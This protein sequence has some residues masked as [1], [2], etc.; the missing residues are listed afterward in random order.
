MRLLTFP[1]AYTIDISGIDSLIN[2]PL[3]FSKAVLTLS[4]PIALAPP[5]AALVLD[6]PPF[7]VQFCLTGLPVSGNFIDRDMEME[8]IE[9][10]L[11]PLKLQYR[12]RIHVLHG[13]GGIGKTQLAI[14]Y[15]RKY[16]ERYSAILWLNGNSYD[17]LLQSFSSFATHAGINGIQKSS[18]KV[19]AQGQKT[20]EEAKA[21]LQWLARKE[22]H[23]WLM[24]FDNVDREDHTENED[25][26]A[27]NIE[28]FFPDTDH[29][30]ILITTRLSHLGQLGTQSKV[31]TVNKEQAFQ[32]FSI[33]SGLSSDI[34]GDTD[35]DLEIIN[36]S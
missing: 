22:N 12:R 21:V 24:I 13:L 14:A 33:N 20:L 19:A 31:T 2:H 11:T 3:S 27:Y 6:T 35:F 8:Q 36:I 7:R 23:G 4:L 15:A 18:I 34:P 25:S 29:G 1:T 32:I 10:S 5:S 17:T 9:H 16:Q 30:S 28:S 26:E